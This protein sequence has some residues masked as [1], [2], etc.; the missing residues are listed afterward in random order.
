MASGALSQ[1]AVGFA[2]KTIRGWTFTPATFEGEPVDSVVMIK[3]DWTRRVWDVG[4]MEL[5]FDE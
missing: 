1:L 4:R 5:D 3:M 2:W